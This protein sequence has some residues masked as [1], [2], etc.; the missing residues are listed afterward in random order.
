YLSGIIPK[1]WGVS[2]CEPLDPK[3]KF[4]ITALLLT[5]YQLPG[6]GGKPGD[7]KGYGAAKRCSFTK[8]VKNLESLQ[9]LKP[10]QLVDVSRQFSSYGGTNDFSSFLQFD[11]S[12]ALQRQDKLKAIQTTEV[13]EKGFKSNATTVTGDVKTPASLLEEQ[14]KQV[15]RSANEVKLKFTDNPVADAVGIFLNSLGQNLMKQLFQKGFNPGAESQ[16][17]TTGPNPLSFGSSQEAAEQFFLELGKPEVLAGG[18]LNVLNEFINCPREFKD[19][20]NCVITEKFK[21]AIEQKL[22]VKEAIDKGLLDPTLPF[23]FIAGDQAPEYDQGYPYRSLVI[24]RKYRVIPISWELAA[25]YINK[26]NQGTI[27]YGQ[28]VEENSLAVKEEGTKEKQQVVAV[29]DTQSVFSSVKRTWKGAIAALTG[30][31]GKIRNVLPT[32]AAGD[33]PYIAAFSTDYDGKT[34]PPNWEVLLS[35]TTFNAQTV[36]L[37]ESNDTDNDG[38]YEE[39][40]RETVAPSENEILSFDIELT[41]STRFT[42]IAYQTAV[43]STSVSKSIDVNVGTSTYAP[44]Q[45]FIYG[46]STGHDYER[47]PIRTWVPITWNV[48]NAQ[49]VELMISRDT[50]NDGVY[51]ESSR[52]TVEFATGYDDP[53][54]D[55]PAYNTRYTLIATNGS[56]SVSRSIDVFVDESGLEI[57]SFTADNGFGSKG[58]AV[59][60]YNGDSATLSWDVYNSTSESIDNG[61]GNVSNRGSMEVKPTATTVYTLTATNSSGSATKSVTVNVKQMTPPII[62]NF[63]ATIPDF[64]T[65]KVTLSWKVKSSISPATRDSITI[66]IDNGVGPKTELEGTVDVDAT[67][68]KTY[69]LTATGRGGASNKQVLTNGTSGGGEGGRG[70]GVVFSLGTL[71]DRFDNCN[72]DSSHP[73]NWACG[74]VDPNWLLTIPDGI[75]KLAGPGPNIHVEPPSVTNVY[76]ADG[77]K[78]GTQVIKSVTRATYC[79]DERTCIKERNDGTCQ[80]YGYCTKEKPFWRFVGKTCPDYL[81][82]CQTFSKPDGSVYSY[83]TN[84]LNKAQCDAG[85]VGC[86][87]LVYPDPANLLKYGIQN[88]AIYLNSNAKQCKPASAGCSRYIR[89]GDFTQLPIDG[90]GDGVFDASDNCPVDVNPEQEDLDQD[91]KGDVCDEDKDNDGVLNGSDNCPDVWNPMESGVQK[92]SDND[93][94]GDAC[95]D[96]EL[97]SAISSPLAFLSKIFTDKREVAP[98]QA[99][100]TYIAPDLIYRTAN[101]PSCEGPTGDED[102]YVGCKTYQAVDNRNASLSA[103]VNNN[104]ICLAECVGYDTYDQLATQLDQAVYGKN[105]IPSV[106][107]SCSASDVG[108]DEFTDLSAAGKETKFYASSIRSCVTPASA[109]DASATYYTWQGSETSGYQLKSWTLLKSNRDYDGDGNF[110]PC[111]HEKGGR[112]EDSVSLNTAVSCS[113]DDVSANPN[114]REFIDR[115]GK[116]YFLLQDKTITVSDSC[117]SVRHSLSGSVYNIIL[118]EARMCAPRAAGCRAYRGNSGNNIRELVN[119]QFNAWVDNWETTG[120]AAVTFAGRTLASFR[121]VFTAQAAGSISWSAESLVVGGHSMKVDGETGAKLKG[122]ITSLVTNSRTTTISFWASANSGTTLKIVANKFHAS[123]IVLATQVLGAGWQSYTVSLPPLP[124]TVTATH[125][126]AFVNSGAGSIY[127]DNIVVRQSNDLYLVKNSW[128]AVPVACTTAS[129]G[130]TAYQE[131]YGGRITASRFSALCPLDKSYCEKVIDTH[132]STVADEERFT[133]Y[134]TTVTVPKDE[135]VWIVND[136]DSLPASVCK[137][138]EMG[139]TALGSPV[140]D[141]TNANPLLGF[142]ERHYLV[143]PDTFTNTLCGGGAVGCTA[144]KIDA[145]NT[146]YRVDPNGRECEY[147]AASSDWFVVGTK[148]KCPSY[149]YAKQCSGEFSSCTEYRNVTN[150]A[151]KTNYYYLSKSVDGSSC[152][153]EN[154]QA[155]CVTF[156]DQNTKENKIVKVQKDRICDEWLYCRT[157]SPAKDGKGKDKNVCLDVGVCNELNSQGQCESPVGAL[158][159]GDTTTG[160]SLGG[161]SKNPEN[162]VFDPQLRYLPKGTGSFEVFRNLSGYSQAGIKIHDGSDTLLAGAFNPGYSQQLGDSFLEQNTGQLVVKDPDFEGQEFFTEAS[163]TKS[164]DDLKAF[165]NLTVNNS[166]LKVS[167]VSDGDYSGSHVMKLERSGAGSSKS[168]LKTAIFQVANGNTLSISALLKNDSLSSTS[169]GGVPEAG[170]DIVCSSVNISADDPSTYFETKEINNVNHLVDGSDNILFAKG[171]NILKY[172]SNDWQSVS[173]VAMVKS[174]LTECYGEV[175]IG[176]NTIGAVKVDQLR[177]GP[178]LRRAEYVDTA[179]S[180]YSPYVGSSC[181]LYP[182]S[183]SLTCSYTDSQNRVYKGY[184]GY[185]LRADPLN[186][187]TCLQWYPLDAVKGET[188]YAV[189]EPNKYEESYN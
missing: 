12:I 113:A 187:G 147:D 146:M 119:E 131:K 47:I 51:E 42:L 70:A 45:P 144:L 179:S 133:K 178:V 165:S 71:L 117:I 9:Q 65:N 44:P 39:V 76:D 136:P 128:P 104:D 92:D 188:A 101:A 189:Q 3:F 130:C 60:I 57:S 35:W 63:T 126:L 15:V 82:S 90:D 167:F 145:Y 153:V 175:Y 28:A 53:L 87:Q 32:L 20:N 163:Y 103:K 88:E 160:L 24:L 168:I 106:G 159:T 74:L 22:T 80:F 7:I 156:K 173:A 162:Q 86:T 43:G 125:A 69:T 96:A 148:V 73:Y 123:D 137:E 102:K 127:L 99:A 116:S 91:G 138:E 166:D 8:I 177:V 68:S 62:E 38:E 26:L 141:Y 180:R 46:F 34:V 33:E 54:Y 58:S 4:N 98:T 89:T 67:S 185:C 109:G 23:G 11:E 52:E 121:D 18:N 25:L 186:R 154:E 77:K 27:K 155:G 21:S 17:R 56:T 13:S 115:A 75:C 132:N 10:E 118:S 66:S 143:Q 37:V 169:G 152:S 79:A 107:V 170:V 94:V 50:D 176:A 1:S 105:F 140:Y 183:D 5:K 134:G 139:C 111:T 181:R 61:I 129:L 85:S 31:T 124:S 108:C 172:D 36:E 78:T 135:Y 29:N 164:S 174:G 19:I 49:T 84:T 81:N 100:T 112:C 142:E 151:D 2:L 120:G 16:Y 149:G 59:D 14:A 48:H 41:K 30:L 184:Q 150:L 157:S 55:D 40:W 64:A 161:S 182:Q 72:Q 114:C 122:S 97:R 93:G 6:L 171:Q 158:G 95:K 110:G 83:L